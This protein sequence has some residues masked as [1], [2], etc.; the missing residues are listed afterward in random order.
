MLIDYLHGYRCFCWKRDW[1]LG[2]VSGGINKQA[3][4]GHF[5]L[6]FARRMTILCGQKVLII[7]INLSVRRSEPS[8]LAR[9]DTSRLDSGQQVCYV[10]RVEAVKGMYKIFYILLHLS[11]CCTIV[12]V[13]EK[14]K[15]YI[16]AFFCLATNLL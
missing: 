14:R 9:F 2:K 4:N 5:L 15:K 7:P 1:Q 8:V 3:G 12:S 10:A 11:L 13:N 6:V 16:S